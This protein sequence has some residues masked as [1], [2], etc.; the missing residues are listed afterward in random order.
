MKELVIGSRGS[1]LAL[2]QSKI[3][4]QLL[5]RRH[6]RLVTRIQT[7]RTT[8]DRISRTPPARA[9][10]TATKG[11]FVKEIEE[12]LLQG[13]VDL[14]VHSLKDLPAELPEGLVI[15]AIPPREDPRDALVGR[16]HYAS[17]QELPHG[18]AVAT[19]SLR[20]QLQLRALRPDLRIRPIRGN[21]ETRIRKMQQGDLEAVVLALAGLRRLGLERQL[22]YVFDAEEMVPAVGQ[23]AL[24]VEVRRDDPRTGPLVASLD[25][26]ETRACVEAERL[27]LSCLGG[28]CQVP[29]AGHAS[30]EQGRAVF[31]ALIAGPESGRT[32]RCVLRGSPGTLA[33]LARQAAE[34]LLAQGAGDLLS[35]E[36][37]EL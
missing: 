30:L 12:A 14:A 7:I 24:A 3:V 21:V 25:D 31:R 36:E 15:G 6:P 37:P 28:G 20:R 13:R 16:R 32:L 10:R 8:G 26:P 9:V 23:G 5:A 35:E 27:F 1:R 19:S 29:I 18:S 17:L 4:Q 33:C 22:S 2:T 34:Q 11:L